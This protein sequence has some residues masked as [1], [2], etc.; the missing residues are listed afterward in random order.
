MF[1]AML[2]LLPL[3]AL[4]QAPPPE[5]DQALRARVT[6]FFQ[7]HVD[8]NFRKAFD[9]VAEDTKDYY[10]ST[11]K[12]RYKSFKINDIKYSDDF[13]KAEVHLTCERMWKMAPQ[14]SEMLITFP[15]TTTWKI[16][17][18]KWVW[19]RDPTVEWATPMGPPS[20][21]LPP[22]EPKPDSNAAAPAPKVTPESVEAAAKQILQ[23]KGGLDKNEVILAADTASSGQV[24]FH[25]GYPG[26]IK[27]A[28]D[29]RAAE[30]IPGLKMELDK[31]NLN[32]N[33][34][35]IVKVHYEPSEAEHSSVIGVRLIVEP[36][37][38]VFPIT[39]KFANPAKGATQPQ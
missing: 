36:F 13:T 30:K 19:Y 31:T 9:L 29:A 32:I 2:F 6:E 17:D 8:G 18:G 5:A 21:T 39:L 1:R 26:S 27:L 24:V 15:L 3:A 35:A 16:E 22:N 37:E 34:N 33:E 28:L 10:F 14:F 23:P 25:N 20:K 38:Q 11:Q 4:A 7:D 12:T